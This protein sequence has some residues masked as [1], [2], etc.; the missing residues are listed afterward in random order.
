MITRGTNE[1][2][3]PAAIYT[4]ECTF[5]RF[6]VINPEQRVAAKRYSKFPTSISPIFQV[7]ENVYSF[8]FIIRKDF[9][10]MKSTNQ[11][12]GSCTSKLPRL[13]RSAQTPL[14]IN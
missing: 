5:D 9:S 2:S 7:V 6:V 11:R 14:L 10:C 4:D 1:M 13:F 8:G 12:T 3:A